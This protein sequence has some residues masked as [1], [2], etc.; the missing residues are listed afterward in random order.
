MRIAAIVLVLAAVAG[1]ASTPREE[2]VLSVDDVLRMRTAGVAPEV[3]V[4]HIRS[5]RV[6]ETLD[7]DRVI[8]LS[9]DQKLDPRV[10]RALVEAAAGACSC[11]EEDVGP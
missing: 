1:C 11:E 4:A 8:A 7:T 2:R 9:R 3:I 5:S 10:L 6:R